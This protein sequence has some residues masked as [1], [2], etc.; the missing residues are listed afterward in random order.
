MREMRNLLSEIIYLRGIKLTWEVVENAKFQISLLSPSFSGE[1]DEFCTYF[2]S[3]HAV[4]F[5]VARRTYDFLNIPR[6]SAF[7]L[8]VRSDVRRRDGRR[9]QKHFILVIRC[10]AGT[11]TSPLAQP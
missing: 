3:E 7:E 11:G 5:F 2:G 1:R 6:T 10:V 9:N 8:G 4:Y